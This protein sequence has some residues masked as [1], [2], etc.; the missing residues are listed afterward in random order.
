MLA[1]LLLV[2]CG[3]ELAFVFINIPGS[4]VDFLRIRAP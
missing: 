2:I 3:S 4:F 1:V